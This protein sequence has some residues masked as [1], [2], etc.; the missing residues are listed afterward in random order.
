MK[1]VD[2]KE[3]SNKC[4]KEGREGK[5][6]AGNRKETVDIKNKIKTE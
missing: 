1:G 4:I 5:G 2:R 3:G 6:R